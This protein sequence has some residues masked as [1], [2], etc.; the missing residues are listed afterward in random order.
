M[1][2]SQFERNVG[3]QSLDKD[4]AMGT[5]NLVSIARDE[6]ESDLV[7]IGKLGLVGSSLLEYQIATTIGIGV[8]ANGPETG[9]VLYS[10]LEGREWLS[11]S[12]RLSGCVRGL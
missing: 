5:S 4:G 2:I 10:E 8:V 11:L 6:E 3:L 7:A 12:N 1:G 9:S